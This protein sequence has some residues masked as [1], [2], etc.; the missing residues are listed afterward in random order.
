MTRE[1]AKA[2]IEARG[3]R[4]TGS[5]TRKTDYVVAGTDAGG[6]KT[7]KARQLGKEP[8]DEATFLTLLGTPYTETR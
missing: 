4:V 6:A 5:V 8:V 1:Q 2:A 3:G 7:E